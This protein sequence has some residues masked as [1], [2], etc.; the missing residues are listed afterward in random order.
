MSE[1]LRVLGQA[2]PAAGT[3][4]TL[5]TVPAARATVVSTGVICNRGAA[6]GTFRAAVRPA[7]ATLA[8][9]HYLYFDVS[10]A[11]N[12]TI[13]ATLG[14]TLATTDVVTVRASSADFSFSLFGAEVVV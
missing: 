3:Y 8:A 14:L 5:Y 4:V 6:A 11:A 13:T 9:L 1:T 10:V 2:A 7:G 12:S